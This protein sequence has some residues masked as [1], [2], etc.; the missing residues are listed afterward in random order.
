MEHHAHQFLDNGGITTHSVDGELAS[1]G[2]KGLF[3]GKTFFGS[4]GH[5]IGHVEPN[6]F[7]GKSIYH[8][9]DPNPISRLIPTPDGYSDANHPGSDSLHLMKL[10]NTTVGTHEGNTQFM[11]YDLG[12]GFPS[13]MSFSDPLLHLTDYLMPQLHLGSYSPMSSTNSV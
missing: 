11:A 9:L 2:I 5:L 1:I 6:A 13:V 3:G 7:G 8:G 10:G 4:D 12:H